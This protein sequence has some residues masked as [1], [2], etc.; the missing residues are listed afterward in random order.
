MLAARLS[1]KSPL[2]VLLVEAGRDTVIEAL[3]E[4]IAD[5]FPRSYANPDYFWPTEAEPRPG[6]PTVWFPQAKVMGGGSSVMGMWAPRGLRSDYN[7]WNIRG[8]SYE[9][10]LTFFN[11]LERDLDFPGGIHGEDGPIP[12]SRRPRSTWPKFTEA[13]ALAAE[14]RGYLFRRDLNGSDQDGLFEMP[15]S[16]DGAI[17]SSTALAYL[18]P[19]V[20]KRA[21]LT[22]L[23]KTEVT[24]LHFDGR[25]VIGAELRGLDGSLRRVPTAHVVLAA[26]AIYSPALLQRSGLGSAVEMVALG[27][28]PILNNPKIGENLRESC[29]RTHR[30]GR[31]C[32]RQ[33]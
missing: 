2:N 21:N 30:R 22:I 23:P 1:E 9:D 20:R 18:T 31:S 10:C 25:K 15:F 26:G 24:R 16:N 5:V 29:L 13:L 4:D 14:K 7:S 6:E 3:P 27:I 11:K 32:G 12:I 28:D 8:W 33:A 19:E 17:R